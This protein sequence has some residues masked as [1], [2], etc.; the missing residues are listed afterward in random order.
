MQISQSASKCFDQLLGLPGPLVDIGSATL[1]VLVKG[2][3]IWPAAWGLV[4][5]F[6]LGKA[7]SPPDLEALV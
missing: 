5:A 3:S 1:V 7:L 2:A 4:K 6:A